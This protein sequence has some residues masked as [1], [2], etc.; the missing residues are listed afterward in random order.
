MFNKIKIFPEGTSEIKVEDVP[1]DT[2]LLIIPHSVTSIGGGWMSWNGRL[3]QT[4]YVG[5]IDEFNQIDCS[6]DVF[7][8]N[9]SCI[10]GLKMLHL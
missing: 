7:F 1:E 3:C 4:V 6:E 5:T 10:D 9:V 2:E 8:P